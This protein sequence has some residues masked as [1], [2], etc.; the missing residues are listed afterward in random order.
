MV[1]PIHEWIF[2]E[3]SGVWQDASSGRVLADVLADYGIVV[4]DRCVFA[5]FRDYE[6]NISIWYR[7]T[8]G[9]VKLTIWEV[10]K[11]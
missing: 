8:A 5:R 11:W 1:K 3:I 10:A 7:A 6:R 9:K 2:R 4:D